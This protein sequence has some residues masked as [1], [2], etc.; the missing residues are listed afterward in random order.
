M[1][2]SG[3]TG[4]RGVAARRVLALVLAVAVA[5]LVAGCGDD[6]SSPE[7]WANGVCSAFSD[8]QDSVTTAGEELRSGSTTKDDLEAAADDLEE[9]TDEF[10]DDIRGLDEVDTEN[11]Q[12]A[13]EALDQLADDIDQNKEDIQETVSG[14]SGVQELVQ[15]ATAVGSTI[16]QMGQQLQQ[17]F[18][19]LEQLDPGS[20]LSDAFENAEAC[21]SLSG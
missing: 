12:Q 3:D 8:W 10:V 21:Q 20:E 5:A 6:E 7:E 14:A 16:S 13:K 19:E 18:R 15:A 4:R 1:Q 2:T 11:G 9:A 17:T